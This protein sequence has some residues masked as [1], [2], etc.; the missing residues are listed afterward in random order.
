MTKHSSVWSWTEFQD[1]SV[2][3]NEATSTARRILFSELS[4]GLSIPIWQASSWMPCSCGLAHLSLTARHCR[5]RASVPPLPSPGHTRV[6]CPV[7]CTL[8]ALVQAE[9]RS[10]RPRQRVLV[11]P[12][13]GKP[14]ALTKV[15]S[16]SR[17]NQWYFYSEGNVK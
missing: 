4:S 12:L 2:F 16:C 13:R 9:V 15:R 10:L 11:P 8:L 7:T 3:F 5:Q 6:S 14:D 1:F 17:G